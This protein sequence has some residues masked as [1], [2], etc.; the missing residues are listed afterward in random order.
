MNKGILRFFLEFF[1]PVLLM[2]VLY[3][4]LDPFMLI[5]EYDSFYENGKPA[6]VDR[7]NDYV[8]TV[9]YDK[10]KNKYNYNSFIFGHSQSRYY[11]VSDWKKYLDSTA[12]CF[13]FDA[14]NESLY[15]ILKKIEYVD[16]YSQI[17]NCVIIL[18][19]SI[20]SK[21]SPQTHSYLFYLSPQLVDNKNIF[22]FHTSGFK[23]F[24]NPKFFISYFDLLI[25]GKIRNYMKNWNVFNDNI[26]GY[27]L[28]YNETTWPEKDKMI[29]EGTYFT[30]DRIKLFQL[31]NENTTCYQSSI[32]TEEQLLQ[33]KKIH[34][35]LTK[36]KTNYKIIIGPSYNKRRISPNDLNTLYNIFNK[37]NVYDFSGTNK[38]TINIENYYDYA[39]YRPHVAKEILEIIYTK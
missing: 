35:I 18:D 6:Y 22:Q 4:V 23:T 36:H 37:Q 32:K 16:K 27:E 1:L 10:Y 13:H 3:I 33:L 29:K 17:K 8:S 5:K 12:S 19:S 11:K 25:F 30:A 14:S 15:G 38:W 26:R 7:N 24:V 34:L 28:Q 9:T 2:L 21:F 39:H 20:L 31:Q